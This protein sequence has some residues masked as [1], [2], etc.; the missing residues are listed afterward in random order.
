MA[1]EG[2][3]HHVPAWGALSQ[4]Y[5]TMALPSDFILEGKGLGGLLLVQRLEGE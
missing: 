3:A 2:P 4:V 1:L 5:I